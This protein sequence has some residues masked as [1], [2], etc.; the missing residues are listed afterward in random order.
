MRTNA[1]V[2]LG[3][4]VFVLAGLLAGGDSAARIA[5]QV[6][7]GIGFLGGGVILRE[8]L[9]VRGLSTAATIWCS[10]AFGVLCGF[11]DFAEAT[12]AAVIVLG[13]NL[14]LRPVVASINR[15]PMPQAHTIAHYTLRLRCRAEDEVRVRALLVHEVTGTTLSLQGVESRSPERD[16]APGDREVAATLS[17][18]SRNDQAVEAVVGRLTLDGGVTAAQWHVQSEQA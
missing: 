16:S 2:A 17:A 3:A 5:G 8:G 9:T 12:V 14:L 10:A 18:P 7:S 13:A 4:A 15:R 6:V 11:G 1:L